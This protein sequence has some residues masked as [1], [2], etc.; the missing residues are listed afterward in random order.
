MN[1]L[2]QAGAGVLLAGCHLMIGSKALIGM[3]EK[4]DTR[5]MTQD[6]HHAGIDKIA[7]IHNA[8]KVVW[9]C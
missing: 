6:S 3:I 1:Q 9:K 7:T 5:R 2:R 8:D 4:V